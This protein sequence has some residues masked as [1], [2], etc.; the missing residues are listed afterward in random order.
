MDLS[1]ASSATYD[2]QFALASS[3]YSSPVLA[4]LDSRPVFPAQVVLAGEISRHFRLVQP[5]VIN[6]EPEQGGK[7]IASDDIFYMYG[8]G[9]TRLDALRDYVTS[10]SEYYAL[11]E[12]RRDAPSVKLFIYLQSYL[13]PI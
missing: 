4:R 2:A 9:A 13:Q 11:L 1:S 12:S 10:L 6:F 8:E 5:I 3:R 7:T